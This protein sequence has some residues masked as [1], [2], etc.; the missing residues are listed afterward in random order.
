[1]GLSYCDI[2]FLKLLQTT[3]GTLPSPGAHRGVTLQI[4]QM[5]DSLPPSVPAT[6]YPS[7]SLL[8]NKH[9][10]LFQEPTDPMGQELGQGMVGGWSQLHGSL[11]A[12]WKTRG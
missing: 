9:P 6:L 1:M 10:C 4:F 8:C 7:N 5:G 11:G 2:L 12:T 3:E